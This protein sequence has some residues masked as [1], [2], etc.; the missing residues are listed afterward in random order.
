MT[1]TKTLVCS[2]AF[3]SLLGFLFLFYCLWRNTELSTGPMPKSAKEAL[4][5]F[6]KAK[7]WRERGFVIFLCSPIF[8]RAGFW[9]VLAAIATAGFWGVAAICSTFDVSALK[10]LRQILR[11]FY[12]FVERWGERLGG[13]SSSYL[14]RLFAMS[15]LEDC[16]QSDSPP[17]NLPC[18]DFSLLRGT[19]ISNRTLFF[20][21]FFHFRWLVPWGQ[22]ENSGI[23]HLLKKNLPHQ[24]VL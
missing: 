17:S 16:P 1:D 12:E 6:G 8:V 5:L 21:R 3:L 22:P 24:W 14:R 13:P 23:C 4:K 9:T 10:E 7:N 15:G 11:D 2:A 20:N 19:P 18:W